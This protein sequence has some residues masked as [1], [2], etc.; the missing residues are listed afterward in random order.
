MKPIDNV[1][2]RCEHCKYGIF[3]YVCRHP[4]AK[5]EDTGHEPCTTKDW[6]H[7]PYSE[8]KDKENK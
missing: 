3:S 1:I 4:K 8:I 5:I 7:C 2:Q 6:E